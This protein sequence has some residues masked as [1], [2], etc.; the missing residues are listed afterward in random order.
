MNKRKK[1]HYI[2]LFISIVVFA[3]SCTKKEEKIPD[4][5]MS[6]QKFTS[7]LAN[8]YYYERLTDAH[9]YQFDTNKVYYFKYV[10]PQ[11]LEHHQVSAP[12][13]QRSYTYYSDHLKQFEEINKHVV[14]TLKMWKEE[15]NY[16]SYFT[17][18]DLE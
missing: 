2:P 15:G 6:Q 9:P 12:L 14:D 5:I 4:D 17:P 1:S 13:Y 18:P 3:F 16:P 11:V 10:L 8:V 7:V